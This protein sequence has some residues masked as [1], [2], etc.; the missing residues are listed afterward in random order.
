MY[1]V[2]RNVENFIQTLG[3]ERIAIMRPGFLDRGKDAGFTEK[4]MLPWLFGTPVAK[5]AAAMVWGAVNQHEAVKGYSTKEIKAKFNA[6][7]IL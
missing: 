1:V 7:N 6:L 2:K 5:V 3:F 4:L